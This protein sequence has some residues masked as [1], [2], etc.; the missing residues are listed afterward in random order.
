MNTEVQELLN[1]IKTLRSPNGCP[2]D[3]EQTFQSLTPYIIE[4]AYELVDA[5]EATQTGHYDNLKEELGDVLL[6]VVMLAAMA[7]EN[8]AFDFSAVAKTISEK[9]IRRHPHVFSDTKVNSVDDVWKNWDAIKKTEHNQPLLA[10]IPKHLPSLMRAYKIQK[11][12]AKQGFDWPDTQGP[13]DKIQE[14]IQEIKAVI[15]SP[16]PN[17]DDLTEEMGDLLFSVVNLSRKLGIDPE[18]A[19]TLCNE[20]FIKRFNYIEKSIQDENRDWADKTPEELDALWE[21]AKE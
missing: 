21:K 2:W 19:L 10:S 5:M 9:M 8:Q 20:K 18:K 16:I 17:T 12:A 3:K 13:F 7:E 4:E 6:H 11:K 15:A 1:I 14:E